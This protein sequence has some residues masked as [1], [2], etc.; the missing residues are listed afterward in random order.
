MSGGEEAGYE[1]LRDIDEKT[2]EEELPQRLRAERRAADYAWRWFEYHA[3]QRQAVFRFYLILVGA[4]SAAYLTALQ[5][6]K[7]ELSSWAFVFGALL[8]FLSFLFWRLD[9][10]SWTLIK[11]AEIYLRRD[12][13]RLAEE[14]GRDE[15][16]LAHLA[17]TKDG[18]KFLSRRFRSFRQIYI[19]MFSVIGTL[20]FLIFFI[21]SLGKIHELLSTVC[22]FG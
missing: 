8:A 6:E 18:T 10:R 12:E 5:S 11:L 9:H 20:G 15:I 7:D 14:T 13:E 22:S 1:V 3:G 17:D 19:Y 2:E 4:A 16:K 21:G